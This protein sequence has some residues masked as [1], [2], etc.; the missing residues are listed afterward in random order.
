VANVLAFQPDETIAQVLDLRDYEV[1]PYLV[2]A[3]KRG[4]VKKTA[5]KDY[6]SPRSGGVIAINLREDDELIAAELVSPD[7]DLL[8]VSKKAQAIRFPA[9]DESLRPMGRATSGVIGM[10]FREDDELLSMNVVKEGT[11][12]FTATDRG[13]GKRTA[14]ERYPVRGRGGLGVIAAKT[15]DERGDLVGALIVEENDEVLAITASGGV[16][17]T[18]VSGL[19]ETGRDT[20]GV[21]LIHVAKKDAVIAIARNAEAANGDA[22]GGEGEPDEAADA[23]DTGLEPEAAAVDSAGQATEDGGTVSGAEPTT[24][25]EA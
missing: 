12:V 8:L 14:V 13:F 7:N 24:P 22:D 17:R 11:F 19:R 25:D 1:A 2:L 23:D 18:G 3:T 10:R 16:I 6:D 15:V 20:M 21:Q 5:L 9:S 4:L